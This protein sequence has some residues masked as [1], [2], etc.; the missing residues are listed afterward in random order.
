MT[1]R[2]VDG[3]GS[4]REPMKVCLTPQSRAALW[5]RVLF[6]SELYLVPHWRILRN[7]LD[8]IA[9]DVVHVIWTIKAVPPYRMPGGS[10]AP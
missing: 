9:L 7:G 2:R 4:V 8:S 10:V 1:Q 5:D 6:L 3:R